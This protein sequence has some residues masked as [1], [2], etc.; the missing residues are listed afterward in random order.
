MNKGT[1]YLELRGN[2]KGEMVMKKYVAMILGIFLISLCACKSSQDANSSEYKVVFFNGMPN[3]DEVPV[4][5]PYNV[6][7]WDYETSESK[8][9]LYAVF[10]EHEAGLDDKE[11][12]E[13][14]ESYEWD[15]NEPD[16]VNSSKINANLIKGYDYLMQVI[17]EMIENT[18]LVLL[19]DY[20]YCFYNRNQENLVLNGPSEVM[21]L[22]LCTVVGTY[23]EIAKIFDGTEP[24]NGHCFSVS[25]APRPDLLE[26]VTEVGY[27]G[28]IE[29]GWLGTW[30]SNNSESVENVIGT[31]KQVTQA[32]HFETAK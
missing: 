19:D 14:V 12:I 25:P 11:Y 8:D 9:T 4:T 21:V 29:D 13:L 32:V 27:K 28:E 15:E 2:E 18:N 5:I 17:I 24:I 1:D 16:E 31:E 26:K 20:P 23:E 10:L 6:L 22:G 30:I 7:C 3:M